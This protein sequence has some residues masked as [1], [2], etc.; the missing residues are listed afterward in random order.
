MNRRR[1]ATPLRQRGEFNLPRLLT[2]CAILF[3]IL[4]VPLYFWK[5]KAKARPM[6]APAER[7][8]SSST[9]GAPP[10]SPVPAAAPANDPDRF[11]LTF[12]WMPAP[13]Y[14]HLHASCHG[15]PKGLER[16]LQ[17]GCNPTHGDTSCRTELAVLCARPADGAA[18]YTLGTAPAV[19]G[20]LL[21]SLDDAN[22]R[23]AQAFGAGWRMA[24]FN[25]NGGGELRGN[26]A[27][28]ASADTR[29]RV[30]VASNDR[31]A[32]CWDKP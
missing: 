1:H 25:D 20:F 28:G 22:A 8:A 24:T 17:G 29:L 12:G 18:P 21:A 11:A 14:E 2:V 27:V 15:E 6:R 10:P 19:A 31:R 26:R 16:P 9:A 7:A 13:D 30:W 23:C 4:L 5:H 3:A 32:N